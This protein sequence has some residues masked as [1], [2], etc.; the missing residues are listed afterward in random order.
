M[1]PSQSDVKYTM[2]IPVLLG[3]GC[4]PQAD[5]RLLSSTRPESGSN[6]AQPGL[7]EL[8]RPDRISY[9]ILHLLHTSASVT[10]GEAHESRSTGQEQR[11]AGLAR[12]ARKGRKEL[13]IRPEH[14]R[15]DG[16]LS[17]AAGSLHVAFADL[18]K[19]R[20]FGGREA[21]R[22]AGREYRERMRLLQVRPYRDR[23]D[24]G[25]GRRRAQGH[26]ER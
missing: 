14:S 6:Q 19:D 1:C 4:G 20:F 7:T 8:D 13:W 17:G 5:T 25:G 11:A 24:A 21:D 15:R 9:T 22:A 2:T 10:Q 23:Q 3:S 16:K 12:F 18:R 26:C